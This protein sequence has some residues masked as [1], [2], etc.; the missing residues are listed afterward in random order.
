MAR[1]SATSS[2]GD[3]S[4]V[5][6]SELK[7]Q[8]QY[9]E[10]VLR[11][12]LR[13]ERCS[14]DNVAA[15]LGLMD[16]EL[17]P[18]PAMEVFPWPLHEATVA[19]HALERRCLGATAAFH[20]T[21]PVGH[22][23]ARLSLTAFP[24]ATAKWPR[25]LLRHPSRSVV[26]NGS[27]FGMALHCSLDHRALTEVDSSCRRSESRH[28]RF[29]AEQRQAVTAWMEKSAKLG[30]VV[31]AESTVA[32]GIPVRWSPF[33][34]VQKKSV[35]G[36]PTEYRVC[37]DLGEFG[38]NV[39][40]FIDFEP[41]NPIGLL[42]LETVVTRLRYLRLRHPNESLWGAKVDLRRFFT[43]FGVRRRDAWLTGQCWCG[44]RIL[45]AAVTFG[46]RSAPHLCCCVINFVCDVMRN[47]GHQCDAFVDDIVL[48]GTRAQVDAALEALLLLLQQLALIENVE[49]RVGP[50]Q[51][52][53]ILGVVFQ[54]DGGAGITL[55]ER[56]IAA[57]LQALREVADVPSGSVSVKSVQSLAGK[58]NFIGPMVPYS[59]WYTRAWTRLL[60]GRTARSPHHHVRLT[61]EARLAVEWWSTAIR[62]AREG[63]LCR[64]DIGTAPTAPLTVVT[65]TQCDASGSGF[66]AACF[67]ERLYFQGVWTESENELSIN[68]KEALAVVWMVAALAERVSGTVLVIHS[69]NLAACWSFHSMGADNLVLRYL[70]FVLNM[71]QEKFRLAVVVQHIAGRRNWVADRLSRG[72]SLQSLLGQQ[73]SLGWHAFPIR[74]NQLTRGI[75]GQCLLLLAQNPVRSSIG[76]ACLTFWSS[77]DGGLLPVSAPSKMLCLCWLPYNRMFMSSPVRE[78][79]V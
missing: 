2:N 74:S 39:N 55:S 72:L 34:V 57:M 13:D 62:A 12:V 71:L 49:K 25:E 40:R 43:Q 35:T 11:L 33:T 4:R 48:L 58:L 1:S 56:K 16:V 61:P 45:N 51:Q 38:G 67:A 75:R 18:W 21:T 10:S 59:K 14:V 66:G 42:S 9:L 52:L 37:H 41:L 5:R 76:Q 78:F 7:W 47:R 8:P 44:R 79:L 22:D 60:A 32:A 46:G 77:N 20:P 27:I 19:P 64:W 63:P 17:V 69:D 31:D 3:R 36:A 73:S 54:L 15:K 65:S 29:T 68:A 24:F 28:A 50:T 26:F 6:Q 53:E 30:L 70:S 23:L